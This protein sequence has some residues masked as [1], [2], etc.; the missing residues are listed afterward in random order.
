MAFEFELPYGD[1]IVVMP[2]PPFD[3]QSKIQ[4]VFVVRS[5]ENEEGLIAPIQS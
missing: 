5:I 3:N 2:R 4:A 1:Q